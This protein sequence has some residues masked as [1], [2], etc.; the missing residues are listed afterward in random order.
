MRLLLGKKSLFRQEQTGA[1]LPSAHS[2]NGNGLT[3]SPV[4]LVGEKDT[5]KEEGAAAS[6]TVGAAASSTAVQMHLGPVSYCTTA[7]YSLRKRGYALTHENG[8][9]LSCCDLCELL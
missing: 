1:Y 8:Y 3:R 9:I 4:V 6:S 7:Y 2:L 5:K